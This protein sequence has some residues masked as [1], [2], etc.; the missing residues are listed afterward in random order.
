[1]AAATLTVETHSLSD[2]STQEATTLNATKCEAVFED[3]AIPAGKLAGS[4]PYSKLSLA[5]SV[6][7]A[8]LDASVI[9]SDAVTAVCGVPFMMIV[10][11]PDGATADDTVT[12]AVPVKCQLVD[13]KVIKT[14]AASHATGDFV[15]ARTAAAGG[16]TKVWNCNLSTGAALLPDGAVGGLNSLDD[17]ATL[18][19]AGAQLFFGRTKVTN[20]ACRAVLTFVPVD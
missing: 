16:G 9:G 11:L 2:G 3:A 13:A 5:D 7:P 6:L 14:A 4:I 18:F 20:T 19:A 10:D 8:D 1:M 17:S 15:H 12:Q